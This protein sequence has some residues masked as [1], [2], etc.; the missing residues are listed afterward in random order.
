MYYSTVNHLLQHKSLISPDTHS[1]VMNNL[2]SIDIDTID[3]WYIAEMLMQKKLSDGYP[4]P[5][6]K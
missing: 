1:Y 2:S 5:V 4:S 6:L 3:D